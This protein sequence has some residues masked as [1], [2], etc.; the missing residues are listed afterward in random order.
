[1]RRSKGRAKSWHTAGDD[2]GTE[3]QL[4]WYRSPAGNVQPALENTDRG[5]VSGRE[6]KEETKTPQTTGKSVRGAWPCR[7]PRRARFPLCS[8]QTLSPFVSLASPAPFGARPGCPRR[9]PRGGLPHWAPAR[10]SGATEQPG[11][12]SRVGSVTGRGRRGRGRGCAA[13]CVSSAGKAEGKNPRFC[14]QSSR[15]ESAW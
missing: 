15:E 6:L 8:S 1:M 5:E 14:L 7:C 3:P 9:R 2:A 11:R 12:G 4:F 10:G 13:L